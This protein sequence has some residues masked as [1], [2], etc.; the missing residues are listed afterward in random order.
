MNLKNIV[1]SIIFITLINKSFGA[2]V[3]Y[4]ETCDGTTTTCA[5]GYTCTPWGQA[6]P[7]NGNACAKECT[8]ATQDDDCGKGKLC[9]PLTGGSPNL[10]CKSVLSA[11]TSAPCTATT[12]C[13]ANTE[14]CEE[15]TLTC[16][17]KP[18]T[19]TVLTTIS[20]P[21]T[22]VTNYRINV[23]PQPCVDLVSGGLY[24]CNALASYCNND[25]YKDLMKA[26]CPKT[27]GYC[28]PTG[29]ISTGGCK[30]SGP[31][32][33]VNEHLCKDTIYKDFMKEQCPMTC[34]YC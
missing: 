9:E 24:G 11:L 5:T 12:V 23:T 33:Y 6:P 32:C 27:C 31:D 20:S 30:D 28:T 1:F 8:V 19:S 10:V 18:T 29:S 2:Q 25:I 17:P 4:G 21:T 7:T 13:D 16:I 34:G 22:T 14:I 26:K 15:H 3:G